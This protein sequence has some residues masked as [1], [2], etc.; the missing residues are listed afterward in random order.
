[1]DN[2]LASKI[3]KDLRKN[4][5]ETVCGNFEKTGY[6]YENYNK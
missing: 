5:I 4:L 3:Y 6:F 1:M 2:E